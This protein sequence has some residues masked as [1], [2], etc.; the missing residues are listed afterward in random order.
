MLPLLIIKSNDWI[1]LRYYIESILR[2]QLFI[3]LLLRNFC[4]VKRRVYGCAILMLHMRNDRSVNSLIKCAQSAKQHYRQKWNR[5]SV[6]GVR[7]LHH[8]SLRNT[9]VISIKTVFIKILSYSILQTSYN[10]KC[11]QI[12]LKS[13]VRPGF[14]QTRTD[15]FES[16]SQRL[17]LLGLRSPLALGNC[18]DIFVWKHHNFNYGKF[19]FHKRLSFRVDIY[20]KKLLYHKIINLYYETRTYTWEFVVWPQMSR[21]KD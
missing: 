2:Y 6:R 18:D 13:K 8:S 15:C 20:N 1:L 10:S 9:Q 21:H 16:V 5:A 14:L 3:K 19:E 4:V 7:Y 12:T 11:L 17:L